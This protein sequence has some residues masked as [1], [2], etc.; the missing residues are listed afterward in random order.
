[1][2]LSSWSVALQGIDGHPVE[3]EA[4]EGGGLPRTQIVGLPDK[5]LNEAKER[6]KAAVRACEYKWPEQLVTINLSPAGLPKA[7]THY[8]LAIAVAALATQGYISHTGVG[9]TVLIGE[10]ALDGR[11][12]RVRGILPAMLAAVKAG[13]ERAIVPYGQQ[14]EAALVPGITVEGAGRL[15]EV[16][17]LVNGLTVA[18]PTEAAPPSDPVPERSS[19][20][21]PDLADVAGHEDGK[22][23]LEVAAA[24]RHHLFL[25]GAP[26]VGKTMLASRLPSILPEL[27]PDESVE[28]SALHSLAGHELSGLITRPPFADPHHSTTQ[29]ALV[30]GGSGELKPGAISLAHRGV[31]FLDECPDFGT[32]LDALRTPLENGWINVSRARMSTRFPARFQLVLAANPCPCGKYG[33][34]GMDCTCDSVKVR[35]YQER[36]SGPILDRIDIKHHMAAVNRVLLAEDVAAPEPS[37]VV[38]DRVLEARARQRYRLRGTPWTTNG[39]VAGPYLRKRLPLPDDLGLLNA[40]L[41]RG[42]ISAR[43]VD[44]VLKLAWTLT[45]LGGA[46]RISDRELRVALQMRQ[47][48]Q[49]R[50][51]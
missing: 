26:G 11:V 6:V 7:G 46:D 14:E 47:G 19:A 23:A 51:A 9:R 43:G 36:L 30:G 29:V 5:A 18:N 44:K 2:S 38:L 40:A 22:F 45:D 32:K 15:D 27:D 10:L 31:L 33:V 25:S 34:A 48:D 42:A 12:R 8:D 3:V 39:E 21:I 50:A 35:R 4:A 24:G 41:Q 20:F 13:F 37:A 17:R 28:V 1:M 49:D 16:V